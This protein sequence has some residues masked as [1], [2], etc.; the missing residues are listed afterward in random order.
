VDQKVTTY[1]AEILGQSEENISL[2]MDGHES[3]IDFQAFGNFLLTYD[4]IA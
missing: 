1:L 4:I 3:N 2:I